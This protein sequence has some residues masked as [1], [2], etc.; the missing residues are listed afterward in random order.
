MLGGIRSSSDDDQLCLDLAVMLCC[1]VLD[2]AVMIKEDLLYQW[3]L[4]SAKS[5]SDDD[6]DDMY[7][8]SLK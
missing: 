6:D 4:T 3:H 8:M 1:E 7:V 5:R 2:L